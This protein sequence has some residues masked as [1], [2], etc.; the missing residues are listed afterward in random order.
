MATITLTNFSDAVKRYYLTR[1]LIRAV[2]NFPH[3][4]WGEKQPTPPRHG[5]V[6]FRRYEG[7]TA[8]TT[9]LTET[10]WGY[11]G[12]VPAPVNPTI[13]V[14][15]VTPAMYGAYM[16]YTDDIEFA[17]IDPLVSNM[18]DILGEQAGLSLDTLVRNTLQ[19]GIT[20]NVYASTATS[21]ATVTS[22]MTFDYALLVKALATLWNANAQPVDG[23][24]WVA[25]AHPFTVADMLKDTDIHKVFDNK[26][27]ASGENPFETGRVGTIL[28]TDFYQTTNAYV[29]AGAGSGGIDVYY[30]LFI[31]RQAYGL[32][33]FAGK[34]PRDIPVTPEQMNRTGDRT[35]PV[36][37][38]AKP[39]GYKDPLDEIGTLGWKFSHAALALNTNFAV[40]AHHATSLG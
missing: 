30:T 35:M 31:G 26:S 24:M 3:A 28:S 14:L 37:I 11:G 23:S 13:T 1:L 32:T 34:E 25:I 36:D 29:A 15:S 33:G 9:A 40:W 22:A 16:E 10:A 5:S 17:S 18:A 27:R 7:L 38:I 4:R 2:P 39:L 12:T 8:V 20:N 19:T 21:D 6:E